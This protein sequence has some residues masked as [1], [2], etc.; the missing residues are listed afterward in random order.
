MRIG[1]TEKGDPAFDSSWVERAHRD[2]CDGVIVITK[3]VAAVADDVLELGLPCI[4]HAT[5]TGLG[6]GPV[7][8]GVPHPSDALDAVVEL[9]R[10][11]FD[12]R[13]VVVRVDPVIPNTACARAAGDVVRGAAARGLFAAGAR[14]RASVIDN[15]RHVNQRFIAAGILPVYENGRF[16]PNDAEVALVATELLRAMPAGVVCETCAEPRL[17]T[18]LGERGRMQGCVSARDLV[19]MGIEPEAAVATNGQQR[20]GCLCLTAKHELLRRRHPCAHGCLYC[21]WK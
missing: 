21:Y 13:H 8:R 18:A 4:V 2:G 12:P 19:L 3:N 9:V 20:R 1:V 7:E 11:G 5:C 10:R 17:A 16:A 15:Y 14:L 6:S